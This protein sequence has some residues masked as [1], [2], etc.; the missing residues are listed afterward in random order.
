M[1]NQ[2]NLKATC[3][4]IIVAVLFVPRTVLA[5]VEQERQQVVTNGKASIQVIV[6]GRG[7]PIVFI[8]S[9]GRGVH[10]FDEL[11]KR[12]VRSGY[13]T[14]LPEPRGI[15]SSTG[16][17]EGITLHDLAADMAAVIQ[18]FG[19]GS[20]IVAGHAFGNRVARVVAT[21]H[22]RLVK[23]VVLLACGGA[24]PCLRRPKRCLPVFLSNAANKGARSRD[25]IGVL[26]ADTIPRFGGGRLVLQRCESSTRR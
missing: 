21:D 6:R 23:H 3:S 8:P 9:L 25:R 13:Q 5:Q 1:F 18:A 11:S 19:G 16:P 10:D 17:L 24:V 14:I 4:L 26:P 12:L 15:G 7:A 20:A 22:P 2:P